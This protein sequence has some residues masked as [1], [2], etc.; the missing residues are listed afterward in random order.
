MSG[1]EKIRKR[2]EELENQ[3]KKSRQSCVYSSESNESNESYES[4]DSMEKTITTTATETSNPEIEEAS[5]FKQ[6]QEKMASENSNID[7]A[8]A[9]SMAIHMKTWQTMIMDTFA[10]KCSDLIESA[11]VKIEAKVAKVDEKTIDLDHRVTALESMA[12]DYEQTKRQCNIVVRGLQANENPKESVKKMIVS[13]LGIQ[14]NEQ[15]IKYCI[16]LTLKN[17]TEGTESVKVSF[18]DVRLRDEIYARRLKLKGS[19]VYISEDLTMKR[20]NLAYEARN[21][22]RATPNSSTWTSE[23]RI[24]LKDSIGG[25]PRIIHNSTDL[26]PE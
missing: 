11:K 5:T 7:K 16:K 20:S 8:I 21:Y 26:K 10:I 15:D 3:S 23:G 6:K 2:S 1:R 9:D 12:D 4:T 25:K 19:G 13:G 18:F 14:M 22:T 24:F 17:E